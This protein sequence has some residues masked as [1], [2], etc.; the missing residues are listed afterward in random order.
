M[1][2]FPAFLNLKDR[3]CLLVGGGVVASRKADLLL[4]AGARLTVV[5]PEIC[6]TLK[7]YVTSGQMTHRVARFT[8]SDVN[9]HW[10]V[11]NASDDPELGAQVFE[12]AN[13]AGVFCNSVD[14]KGLCS[15]ITPAIIDRSPVVVAVSSGGAAPL[16]ARKI[17]TQIETMLP[18][19][20]GHL[21]TLASEWRGR[22]KNRIDDLLSRRRFWEQVFDGAVYEDVLAGRLQ[23]AKRNIAALLEAATRSQGKEG[24]A[25][26]VGAGPGDPG[27]L[28][29]RALQ[30][31]Q[32]ADVIVHDRLVSDE[33]L[34]LAR[35]DAEKISVGK[36]PGCRSTTQEEIN[37]LLIRLVRDG[38]RVCRLKGGDPFIFGRGGEEME[39]LARAEIRYQVVPGITAAAGCAA[40]A[41]I[42]LTHRALAQSVVLLTAHEKDS[43]D[44]LDWPSLARD[45]QTLALYM[46]VRRFP[47]IQSKLVEYGRSPDTPIAI[48]ERGTSD[49]QRVIHG[50][51]ENLTN[52][53][54]QHDV[55]APAL[56]IVGEVAGF[57]V[58]RG[59][60]EGQAVGQVLEAPVPVAVF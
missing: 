43:V 51:L 9:G 27:L 30:L 47:D 42:P 39:A 57:G 20:L 29:M 44:R 6:P 38:K 28:T 2:Y 31:M 36:A 50:T 32:R 59:W 55:V 34:A 54:E 45:R 8:P 35:R 33:V 10:L 58:G 26:L 4:A 56:L 24:E 46:A 48:I 25:W 5:A 22:V 53:A 7:R 1:D 16:L 49:D 40:Y 60:F 37:E 21:A 15:Y 14:D 23:S 13:G 11:V 12:A 52:L 17:R 41:G 3:P 18:A 19:R